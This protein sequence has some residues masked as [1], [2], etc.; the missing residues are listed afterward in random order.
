MEYNYCLVSSKR[1][2]KENWWVSSISTK[3]CDDEKSKS[4]SNGRDVFQRRSALVHW[5]RSCQDRAVCLRPMRLAWSGQPKASSGK[6]R[7]WKSHMTSHYHHGASAIPRPR[8]REKPT[9]ICTDSPRLSWR[10]LEGSITNTQTHPKCILICGVWCMLRLRYSNE[11]DSLPDTPRREEMVALAS[12][13]CYTEIQG[14]DPNKPCGDWYFITNLRDFI[15]K[16]L[17]GK[18]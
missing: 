14:R 15:T 3:P 12:M 11:I 8:S 1:T 4:L 13:Y 9:V 6:A 2:G 5:R 10:D 17:T 16:T 7:V 18:V